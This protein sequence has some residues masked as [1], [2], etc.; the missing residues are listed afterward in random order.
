MSCTSLS[1]PLPE[2]SGEPRKKGARGGK[3]SV[4][5]LSKAQLARKRANDREA[6]RN[7][8]KRTKEHISNLERKVKEL[9]QS[10]RSS[11]MER[12]LKRNQDLEA[13][14]ERLR[15][16]F[17]S[18]G[19]IPHFT[20]IPSEMS[21]ELMTPQKVELH[22]IPSSS[23][24]NSSE[25]PN[26]L[27]SS[28]PSSEAPSYTHTSFEDESSQNLY[29]PNAS[30][31][32]NEQTVYGPTSFQP[33]SRPTQS[34]APYQSSYPS[35]SRFSSPVPSQNSSFSDQVSSSTYASPSWQNQP[36]IYAWQMSTK[37]KT[38]HA[39]VDQLVLGSNQNE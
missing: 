29:L 8:R 24:W 32:W 16:Q 31:A 22:W 36:S 19:Q 38:P 23:S 28:Y 5:H 30:P 21:E 13:E 15:A 1:S 7:I 33:L 12:I 35:S 20:R 3:R 10:G 34:W 6:Q 18:R 39:F 9:E 11:S 25:N 37:I 26:V 14:I 27:N 2:I 4:T 17:T